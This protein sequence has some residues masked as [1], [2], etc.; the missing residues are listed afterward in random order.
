ML[1][2]APPLRVRASPGARAEV[3]GELANGALVD[4]VEVDGAWARIEDA[5]VPAG[6][7]FRRPLYDLCDNPAAA[8]VV[9]LGETAYALLPGWHEVT[10]RRGRALPRLRGVRR[11][12][13]F[14]ERSATELPRPVPTTW[15]REER[16]PGCVVESGRRVELGAH[17]PE[18]AYAGPALAM[19]ACALPTP[20]DPDVWI[21][22]TA[23]F[24]RHPGAHLEAWPTSATTLTESSRRALDARDDV[25]ADDVDAF[26]LR[27]GGRTLTWA[28]AEMSA[29][30][31]EGD[32]VLGRLDV[33]DRP[34]RVMRGREHLVGVGSAG[35]HGYFVTVIPRRPLPGTLL[36]LQLP[37]ATCGAF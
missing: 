3:L 29:W 16:V 23:V 10:D 27:M 21:L 9:V 5:G 32:V 4:V 12:M 6:W 36:T 1:D 31:L 11:V 30:V 34:R 18:F 35:Y 14:R 22:P 26:Q 8:P 24:G 13:D 37:N 15:A 19:P 17:C 28:E 2:P 25:T 20:E 33:A 7:V